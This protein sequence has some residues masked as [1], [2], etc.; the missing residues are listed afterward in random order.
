MYPSKNWF[1]LTEIFFAFLEKHWVQVQLSSF[2]SGLSNI[3]KAQAHND[4]W[5]IRYEANE[6]SWGPSLVQSSFQCL[7]KGPSNFTLIICN[8]F[9]REAPL[10]CTFYAPQNLNSPHHVLAVIKLSFLLRRDAYPAIWC[11]VWR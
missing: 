2:Y 3:W 4:Q 9:L 6:A 1:L 10:L 11:R 7:G 5:Q 8:T